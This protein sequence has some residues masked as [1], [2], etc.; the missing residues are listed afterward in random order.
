[1]L[2]ILAGWRI[3]SNSLERACIFI[4]V[5]ALF[6]A[7]LFIS[8]VVLL[9]PVGISY[10]FL[11]EM[12][13]QL[14][15]F[16]A[17][18]IMGVLLK[19]GRHVSVDILEEHLKGRALMALMAVIHIGVIIGACMIIRASVIAWQYYMV[20]GHA[21]T[22]EIPVPTWAIELSLVIGSTVLLLFAVEMT[23]KDIASLVSS[24]RP[25]SLEGGK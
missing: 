1:M 25:G 8:V 11:Q 5:T 17:F 19:A 2:R 24:S 16:I 13:P 3:F 21:F 23:V 9:R 15:G 12:P 6:V 7:A 18:P 22:T 10:G 20:T 14:A 4:S